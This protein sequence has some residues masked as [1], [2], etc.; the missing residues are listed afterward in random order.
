MKTME[1]PID[2]QELERSAPR[3]HAIPKVDPFVV[4]ADLFELF[5]HQVQSMVVRRDRSTAAPWL[6]RVAVALPIAAVL[7]VVTWMIIDTK[8]PVA[9]ENIALVHDPSMN[10]L[11]LMQDA[12]DWTE[13]VLVSEGT[14]APLELGTA[15]SPNEIALYFDQG[16]IDITELLTDL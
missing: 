2:D 7:A 13:L 8:A 15:I 11:L 3:L 1:E 14:N 10:D 5:P 9:A 6:R 12:N 16:S 4:P